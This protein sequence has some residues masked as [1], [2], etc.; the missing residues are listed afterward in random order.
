MVEAREGLS[1]FQGVTVGNGPQEARHIA[2][3]ER[4]MKQGREERVEFPRAW[5]TMGK[6]RHKQALSAP[7]AEYQ[8]QEIGEVDAKDTRPKRERADQWRE[9]VLKGIAIGEDETGD[10]FWVVGNHQLANGAPCIIADQGYLVEIEGFQKISYE[11][12]H[13][14]RTQI[15]IWMHGV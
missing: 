14:K 6:G 9:K 15:R 1:S 10:P 4:L 7:R 5:P 2:A 12:S 8:C 3:G 13:P 11:V